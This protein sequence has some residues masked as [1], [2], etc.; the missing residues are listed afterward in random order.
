MH[1]LLALFWS[2]IACAQDAATVRL[3]FLVNFARYVEWPEAVLKPENPLKIC[4]AP[5]DSAM[6]SQF[7]ELVKQTVHGR[8]IQVKQA[9]R[10]SDAGGCQVLYLPSELP[11]SS[12]GAWLDV[13]A[14][15][16]VLTVGEIPD[17]IEMG[18]MIGLVS[19]SGRYRFDI[20]LGMAR[21]ADLRI[22]TYVLKLARTVK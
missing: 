4:L 22:S 20:N 14:K 7:G 5:G 21:Q 1:I 9:V 10:P 18:G 19:V 11:T 13:V 2:G 12:V 6:A 8:A 15:S 3:G 17:F 16:G